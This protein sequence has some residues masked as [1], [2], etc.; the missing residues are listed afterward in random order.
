MHKN[1]RIILTLSLILFQTLWSVPLAFAQTSA[2]QVRITQVDN[3]KFPRVTVYISVTNAAG[4][5]VGVDPNSIQIL[6]NGQAVLAENVTG[7]G[8]IGSLTTLLVIDASGSMEKSKK[9]DG[10]RDAAKAYVDQMRP[11]DKAGLVAFNTDIKVVQSVTDDHQAL[12]Q[13]IDSLQPVGNTALFDALTKSVELLSDVSGR[14]TIILL[15][16]GLDNRSQHNVDDVIK[17]I[18]PAGLSIS[19]IGLGDPKEPGNN[20]GLDELALRSLAKQAGGAYSFST[21]P[22]ALAS[23]YQQ[24]GRAL[25]SEYTFTYLSPSTLRDGVNRGLTVSLN[26]GAATTTLEYNPGGVLP[27]VAN[28]SWPLFGGILLGLMVLLALPFVIGSS[29]KSFGGFRKKGRVKFTQ[30]STDAVAKGRVKMK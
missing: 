23:I 30:P 15:S 4:E 2:P 14:K 17:N 29:S 28:Q 18:G 16:D 5:P 10:A 20:Y 22:A 11:G 24:Y 25:Q 8:D 13:A 1:I 26:G 9:M 19:T 3:S 27:E 12:S 6:E 7:A 21:D